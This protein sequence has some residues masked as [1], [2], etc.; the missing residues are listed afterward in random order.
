MLPLFKNIDHIMFDVHV[1]D[2]NNIIINIIHIKT[3]CEH[4][5]RQ[6]EHILSTLAINSLK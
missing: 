5:K 3:L 4:E 1:Y 2:R 6:L